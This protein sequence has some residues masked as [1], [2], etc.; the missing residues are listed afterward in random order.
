MCVVFFFSAVMDSTVVDHRRGVHQSMEPR[1]SCQRVSQQRK[2]T[3]T[4]T[5]RTTEQKRL[6]L[7]CA[8]ACVPLFSRCANRR[9]GSTRED[10]YAVFALSECVR[11]AYSFRFFF[12]ARFVFREFFPVQTRKRIFF[13]PVGRVAPRMERITK[14]K[15]LPRR[16]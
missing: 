9:S 10:I 6:H 1:H 3:T 12:F 2:A 14:N 15:C 8:A 11:A 16:F 5:T 4:T 13:Y 7:T